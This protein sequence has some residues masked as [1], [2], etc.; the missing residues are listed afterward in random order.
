MASR[1]DQS[2]IRPSPECVLSSDLWA[3]SATDS[4]RNDIRRLSLH[5]HDV[6]ARAQ[7]H[8]SGGHLVP[9]SLCEELALNESQLRYALD[10]YSEASG[11]PAPTQ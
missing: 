6:Y 4:L 11:H 9:A 8:R 5:R 10:R 3:L 7:V 2:G 1:A